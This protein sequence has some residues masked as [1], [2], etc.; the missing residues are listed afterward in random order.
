MDK[1][2]LILKEFSHLGSLYFN[3]AYFGP[4]PKRA[5]QKVQKA[6]DRELDPSFYDYNNWMGIPERLRMKLADLIGTHPDHITLQTSTSDVMNVVAHSF[7]F[8]A[9]DHIAALKGDYPSNVLSW[10]MLQKRH[11]EIS[12]DLIDSAIEIDIAEILKKLHVKTKIFSISQTAFD[13]GRSV[14]IIELGKALRERDILFIVDGTQSLGGRP[15]YPE[16]L[17][18]IDIYCCSV[19]KWMLGPYGAA[20]AYFSERALSV[21]PCV[22]GNWLISPES[23][24]VYNLLNYTTD[25]LAGA[26]RFDRG[27]SPNMLSNACLEGSLEFLLEFGQ[28]EIYQSNQALKKMFLENYPKTKYQVITPSSSVGN[29]LSIK[30]KS[31]D[32]VQLERELKYHNIDVSVRQ[33]N[34]RLSFHLF[35]TKNQVETLMRVLDL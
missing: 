7:P 5:K 30:A 23:K 26:R 17:K 33:G 14:D 10:M 16:E 15:I 32:S 21:L 28:E 4:S 20:F 27:Q 22:S 9:G 18:H 6:L 2:T 35:N 19:Y 25:T 8:K 13:T 3:S 34:I 12:F 1:E 29:I 24:V 31:I 11:P